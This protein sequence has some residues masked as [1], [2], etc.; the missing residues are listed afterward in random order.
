MHSQGHPA[1]NTNAPSIC[2]SVVMYGDK[3]ALMPYHCRKRRLSSTG[4]G[5][6]FLR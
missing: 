5:H 4:Q 6:G 3:D 1:A 2:S